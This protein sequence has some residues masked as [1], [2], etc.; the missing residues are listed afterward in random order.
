L[1]SSHRSYRTSQQT[2]GRAWPLPRARSKDERGFTLVEL[3]VVL[4][5]IGVLAAIAIPSFLSS[6]GRAKDAQA[7]ELARTA[8]TTAEAIAAGNG[9]SYQK[10]NVA[11]LNKEEPTIDIVPSATRAYLSNASSTAS[12]YSVTTTATDGDELTISRDQ[13]GEVTRQC[14]S[15]ITKTGCR[16]GE[17]SSW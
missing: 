8:E 16:G 3:L 5:I 12:E 14:V 6:T 15:P 11:E 13:A 4:L 17:T 10:V 7:K 2:V 9:G 1:Y